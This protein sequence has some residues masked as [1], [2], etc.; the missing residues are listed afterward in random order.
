MYISIY[1]GSP[2]WP[3]AQPLKFFKVWAGNSEV[4]FKI[5]RNFKVDFRILKLPKILKDFYNF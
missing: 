5:L 3:P 1:R 4:N 2:P